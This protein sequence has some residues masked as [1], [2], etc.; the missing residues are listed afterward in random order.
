M[1]TDQDY[2][3]SVSQSEYQPVVRELVTYLKSGLKDN[4]HSVYLYGSVA[5]G[6]AI[7]YL[8]NIDVVVITHRPF[9]DTKTT[10]F[11]TINWRFQRAYPFVNGVSIRTALV[12]EVAS[13]EALF[14][15]GFLLRECCVCIHGEDLAECFGHF[16]PS[17]EI[18]KQWNMDT[19][20]YLPVIRQ[21]IATATGQASQIQLQRKLAKKLLRAAYSL[22][23]HKEKRWIEEPLECGQRFLRYYPQHEQTVA[24]LN[25]LLGT[26]VIPK[27]SV[28]GL[29]DHFGS[30]LVEEYKKTEFKIG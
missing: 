16:V 23:M 27:R 26:R 2:L 4:L 13:L 29:L 1:S 28:V 5:A 15:W 25:I 12:N 30:W 9:S 21:Q 11:N 18:A 3:S 10:L 17:W 22:V 7:P 20:D 19:V 8:S 6:R 24:R 14:T